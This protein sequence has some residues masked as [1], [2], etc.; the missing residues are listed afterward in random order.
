M[1]VT[2][3]LG[4]DDS[5]ASD[6]K[7]CGKSFMSEIISPSYPDYFNLDDFLTPE[8]QLLLYPDYNQYDDKVDKYRHIDPLTLK[9]VFKKVYDYLQKYQNNFPLTHLISEN[10]KNYSS[11]SDRF[12]YKGHECYIDG[13]HHDYNHRHELCLTYWQNGWKPLEWIKASNKVIVGDKTYYVQ[14]KNKFEQYKDILQE[15][16]DICEEGIKA[17]RRLIWVF[18]N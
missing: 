16:I 1:G 13:F 7:H 17:N 8:E 10:D 15:L 11:S 12:N 3:H 14:T 2:L 18:S 5:V 4:F 6:T 9:D